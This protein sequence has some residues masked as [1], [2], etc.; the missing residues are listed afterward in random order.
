[1]GGNFL[2]CDKRFSYYL[3]TSFSFYRAAPKS[4]QEQFLLMWNLFLQDKWYA[5]S[6]FFSQ[7]FRFL[8]TKMWKRMW[9]GQKTIIII[10]QTIL[11]QVVTTSVYLIWIDGIK[12]IA[13]VMM[14]MIVV[15]VRVFFLR[16]CFRSKTEQKI[17]HRIFFTW[18]ML[19]T[20]LEFFCW[21]FS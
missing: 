1:M 15:V 13:I 17:Q 4:C 14:T 6:R 12:M 10:E 11:T 18:S 19:D 21:W 16:F 8:R 2:P 20:F 5:F 3:H 9:M 7:L